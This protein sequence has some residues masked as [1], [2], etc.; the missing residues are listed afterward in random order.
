M[1][2]FISSDL[3]ANLCQFFSALG[4]VAAVG[5]S[6]CLS[7]SKTKIKVMITCDNVDILNPNGFKAGNNVSGYGI[8]IVN[9]SDERNIYLKQGLYFVSDSSK[10]KKMIS[11]LIPIVELNHIFPIQ[12]NLGP[13]DDF[14]FFISETHINSILSVCK[15]KY[16]K[17]YFMDKYNRKYYIKIKKDNL[18]KRLDYIKK[19]R[20]YILSY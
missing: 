1:V 6:L 9:C 17:F 10:S 4:T 20:K 19:N 13:G 18:Q 2:D 7:F 16:I 14:E 15:K 3:F 11:L 8:R 5:V 12:K